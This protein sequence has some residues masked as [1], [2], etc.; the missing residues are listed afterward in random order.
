MPKP[1]K[2]LFILTDGGRARFVERSAETGRFVTFEELDH[3]GRLRELRAELRATPPARAFSSASPRRSGVGPEDPVRPAKEAFMGEVAERAGELV[4]ARG[5]D[6]V[7][8]AAPTRLIGPLRMRL[9]RRARVTGAI[10]KDLT[11]APDHHLGG[12]LNEAARSPLLSL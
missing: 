1:A 7:V 4:R 8:L 5:L 12:W 11:K 6:G 2:L 3:T 10:R 9:A